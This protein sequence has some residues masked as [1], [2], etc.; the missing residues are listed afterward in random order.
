[1]GRLFGT[2]GV[3]GVANKDLTCELAMK[4]GRA[5]AAVLTNKSTRHPRVIIGKDTRLSSDMLENA[6]AAGLCSVGA[7][8]VLLG[9]VP[10]PAV[11]YLVEKYKA[12]AGI[13][14]S[15]S[16]NT[17]EYNGIKIFDRDGYKLPDALEDH[18]E[19]IIRGSGEEIEQPT[20]ISVGRRI[21]MRNARRDYLD[22]LR[23]TLPQR[24]DGLRIVLDCAN[25]SASDYAPELF[26]S[27]GA[28]V[29]PYFCTPD[30][31]D[32]NDHCGSTH[33]ERLQQLVAEQGADVGLAFDG[34]ADR[35]IAVDDRGQLVD[36][37]Q[38]MTMCALDMR[39]RGL[40]KQ[41]TVV[42]TVMSNLGMKL[43]LDKLGIRNART[44]VGDRYV[45]EHMR[46]HGF[47]L[48]GEQ[49]GHIIF[50]DYNTT[51]DGMLSA[52]QL[53][54]IMA[55]K[56]QSLSRLAQVMRVLPQVLLN[57]RVSPEGRRKYQADEEIARAVKALE[58]ELGASG[59]VL[60]RPSGT[61]PLIRVMIEGPDQ[62]QIEKQAYDLV[63]LIEQRCA[64]E[65]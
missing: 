1:M 36:G 22:F 57:A 9:V 54:G 58:D 55:R 7:S 39:E 11:A 26:T 42:S 64:D 44:A 45:L 25:G 15:A 52:L 30:G 48:G 50:L 60:I 27:L 53:L 40:L 20:G 56:K 59:R 38:L 12:D 46:E 18:I 8:V 24:L 37:D 4:L 23:S 13:M 6:M 14:I 47:N 49:S 43:A 63:Q 31:T 62:A 17:V 10:T 33:P 41:D 5:A 2:D 32:I 16:H 61:E 28:T 21:R 3:R 65:K 51:G 35:L 34:D 29:L 19:A